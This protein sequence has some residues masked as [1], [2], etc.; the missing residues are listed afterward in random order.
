MQNLVEKECGSTNGGDG[1][2]HKVSHERATINMQSEPLLRYLNGEITFTQWLENDTSKSN[3]AREGDE[4]GEGYSDSDDDLADDDDLANDDDDDDNNESLE[5]STPDAQNTDELQPV[6]QQPCSSQLIG[7]RMTDLLLEKPAAQKARKHGGTSV[8]E[9]FADIPT[10][11]RKKS[12]GRPKRGTV[13]QKYR[14]QIGEANLCCA[15]GNYERAKEICIDII[16]QAPKCAEPFQVLGMVYEMQNDSEKALQFFLISAYLKK[17]EDSEDWL[18]LA[19]MSLEQGNYKQALACYN[20]ALKHN[21]DDP[22]ILWERAAVCYQMGDV[23]KALEYYQVA[24]KAFPNDD[25]EKLMD[26]AVEMATIYHEQGSLLDA[27]VAMEAAFSRV[28]RCSDFRA[29]N[30]LAELYMTA[31]QYSKSLKLICTNCEIRQESAPVQTNTE[32]LSLFANILGYEIEKSPQKMKAS[33]LCE[34]DL[35]SK[36]KWIIPDKV[37]IDLRVKT[38]V[39]LIHLHCLQPVKDIIAPLYFESVDDVGDLYLDVAEAY[40]ENSNYEE[41]LPIFDILVTTEKYNQAGVWLNKAQSL[42]SL[43]RLEEAAAACTQVVSLA[44]SHLEARVQLSSLLQQLG[45]HDKAI[46]ILTSKPDDGNSMEIAD[47][48]SVAESH[49]SESQKDEPPEE[50]ME[51]QDFRLLYHKCTLLKS[52]D[53]MEDF[54]EA[55]QQMFHVYFG[56][57]SRKPLNDIIAIAEVTKNSKVRRTLSKKDASKKSVV[58]CDD[59][60]VRKEE[61]YEMLKQLIIEMSKRNMHEEALF[62]DMCGLASKQLID[63]I[64][65]QKELRFMSIAALFLVGRSR[66]AF[67]FLRQVVA[68]NPQSFLLWNMLGRVVGHSQDSRHHRYCLRMLIKYP[69]LL[70]L[71]VVNGHNS[72]TAGSFKFAIAEYIRAFRQC[73]SD[74]LI[75][76]CMGIQ[77]IHLACQRFPHKR[78]SVVIQGFMFMYQYMCLRGKGQESYY[79]IGRAFHQLGLNHFAVHYYKLALDSPYHNG[80]PDTSQQPQVSECYDLHRE[81]AYNLSLIYRASGNTDLARQIISK[82]IVF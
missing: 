66:K 75:S 42:I 56:D 13:P 81:A 14:R 8:D 12:K 62:L 7:S 54:I 51:P 35:N 5:T 52:Q 20:Q 69:D 16:K 53:R 38:V 26:L 77:Y 48:A 71:V 27:I 61:W 58:A 1:S 70:P 49:S 63:L 10:M 36:A 57:V 55:A 82:Y 67:D 21:P 44:P 6:E 19:S 22:T 31:K 64:Q 40:A 73:P 47:S 68:E 23:K 43:G 18:K 46:E 25:L 30:M 41:A 9:F 39:C 79:N 32:P 28:Q 74:P 59:S 33:L 4:Q 50:I 76:L 11:K 80:S 72:F 78:N 45:R 3:T 65:P 2:V 37:P 34:V 15:K 60:F 24:L 29:I 17:S